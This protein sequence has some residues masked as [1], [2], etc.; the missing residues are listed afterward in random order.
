MCYRPLLFGLDCKLINKFTQNIN[1]NNSKITVSW[2]LVI[3]E[4]GYS[5]YQMCIIKK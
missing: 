4:F 5:I 3:L 1:I 2:L